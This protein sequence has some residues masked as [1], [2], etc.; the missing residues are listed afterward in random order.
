MTIKVNITTAKNMQFFK[1]EK[2]TIKEVE[3]EDYVAAVVASEIG[4]SNIEACKAQAIAA[5]SFA[6]ARGVLEGKAISDDAS[7]AQAYVASRN[8]YTRCNQA[9]QETAGM[10]LTYDNKCASTYYCHSNGG[11]TYS[12]KEVWGQDKPYL[13]ARKDSWTKEEKSGHGIGLSQV[14]AIYAGENGVRFQDI[15]EFYYPGT[16]LMQLDMDAISYE[17]RILE[18]IKVRLEIALKQIS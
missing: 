14:G 11:R 18:D 4:N 12:C 17:H 10:V 8:N 3:L 16:T 6:V 2:N 7:K 5:R 15:L 9:A 13:I 1:C